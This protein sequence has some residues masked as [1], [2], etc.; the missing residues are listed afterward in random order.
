MNS[1]LNIARS[2]LRIK[3]TGE[4][5]INNK[6]F[7]NPNAATDSLIILGANQEIKIMVQF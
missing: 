2:D 7:L 1:V 5:I 4:M 3:L 6:R